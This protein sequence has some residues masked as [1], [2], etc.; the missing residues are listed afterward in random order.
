MSDCLEFT[1]LVFDDHLAPVEHT[2]S[3]AVALPLRTK[4]AP[5]TTA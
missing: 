2:A 1:L 3:L 4:A 5:L